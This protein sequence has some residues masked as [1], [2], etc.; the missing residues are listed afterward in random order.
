M[1][2]HAFTEWAPSEPA[3]DYYAR[4]RCLHE[5]HASTIDQLA[6]LMGDHLQ[7]ATDQADAEERFA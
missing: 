3:G 5:V 1:D 6:D 4:C 7:D 2:E